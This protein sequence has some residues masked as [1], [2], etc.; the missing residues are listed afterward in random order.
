MNVLLTLLARGGSQ[1]VPSKNIKVLDGKPLI[2]YTIVLVKRLQ[3]Q[4]GADIELSTD[5]SEI[6][7]VAEAYG[8][9]TEYK[10]PDELANPVISKKPALQHLIDYMES[11]HSKRYDY[12]IDFD[13]T[14]PLRKLSDILNALEMIQSDDSAINLITVSKASRNP[15][16]N[17]VEKKENGYYNVCKKPG[18]PVFSR[19]TAPEVFDMNSNFY[20]FTR[21][22]FES[23]H[24]G[25]LTDKT[26]VYKIEHPC[27]DIDEPMDFEFMEFLFQKGYYD[28]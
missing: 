1:G 15:Y 24:Q 21:A 28:I 11:I 3:E 18:E 8:L 17:M 26:L 6:I 7:D 19:Q 12:I 9:R 4:L 16:F 22:Y 2:Y 5:S 10:R 23:V 27:F 25:T 14:A 20:I 13:L